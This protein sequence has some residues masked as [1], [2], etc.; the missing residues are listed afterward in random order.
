[1]VGAKLKDPE[2]TFV[3][4]AASRRSHEILV[5]DAIC[6]LDKLRVEVSQKNRDYFA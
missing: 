5:T 4:D 3:R 6:L 2:N 1:M